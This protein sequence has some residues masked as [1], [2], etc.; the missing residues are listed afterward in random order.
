MSKSIAFLCVCL[1]TASA[2]AQESDETDA[3]KKRLEFGGRLLL[4]ADYYD[5]FWSREDDGTTTDFEVR[6]TRLEVDYD[7]PKGWEGNLQINA[8]ID[9]D[10]TEVDLGNAYLTYTKFDFADVTI[11]KRKEPLG[12]ERNTSALRMLL[13]ERSMVTDELTPAKNWGVH[14]A[15]ADDEFRWAASITVDDDQ[16]DDYEESPPRAVS[17]KYVWAPLSIES[18]DSQQLQ[19]GVSGSLREWN[20]NTFQIR[21]RAEVSSADNVVRSVRFTADRQA[22]IGIEG[23]WQRNSLLV[24]A[25]YLVTRVE[26]LDGPDWD[27]SGYQVSASL[28]VTDDQHLI[29]NTRFR[30]VRPKSRSGAWELVARYSY[31]D[32][33]DRGLGSIASIA[34]IGVNYYFGRHIRVMLAYLHPDIEGSVRHTSPDGNAVTL[35]LQFY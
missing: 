29:R 6:G 7:F 25:E 33:Q 16:D 3:P 22:I 11:G 13:P 19:I 30:T 26:E 8:R 28:F 24:A 10:D 17:G 20:E 14:L 12:L 2:P 32:A 18:G 15:Q 23:L 4:D 35:R 9:S 27:F 31:L 34:S 5:S 21:N 1:F